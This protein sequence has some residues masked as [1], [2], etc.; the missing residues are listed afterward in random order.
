MKRDDPALPESFGEYFH[1]VLFFWGSLGDGDVTRPGPWVGCL[2]GLLPLGVPKVKIISFS[3]NCSHMIDWFNMLKSYLPTQPNSLVRM[4]LCG[5]ETI[6]PQPHSPITTWGKDPNCCLVCGRAEDRP[7]PSDSTTLARL[8]SDLGWGGLLGFVW[9]MAH[10]SKVTAK[11][12][13]KEFQVEYDDEW[14]KAWSTQDVPGFVWIHWSFT[15]MDLGRGAEGH[16]FS[17]L[18]CTMWM[19]VNVLAQVVAV[20]W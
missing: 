8:A 11:K 15:S 20:I 7:V 14:S 16:A 18:F 5:W 12:Y 3:E 6:A 4:W 19:H 9:K 17:I 1:V 10:T 13:L 2:V